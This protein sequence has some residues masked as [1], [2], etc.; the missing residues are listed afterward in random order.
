MK[1]YLIAFILV[2]VAW[3]LTDFLIHGIILKS[4]YAATAALW[5][6]E[7]EMNS[8]LATLVTAIAALAFTGIYGALINP[9][10]MAA[11][12]KF[13]MLYGLAAGV[14]MGLGSYCYTPISIGL[15]LMWFVGTLI[16]MVI[17]GAIVGT[18]I[19]TSPPEA[20]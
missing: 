10:S 9:K 14:S 12:I 8:G 11:G 16:Q 19:K 4:T 20:I 5:R 2:F 15:A 13:G 1:S 7:A 6:P 3:F 17:A 18:A